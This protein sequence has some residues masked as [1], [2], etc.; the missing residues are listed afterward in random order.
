MSSAYPGDRSRLVK[1]TVPEQ[2]FAKLK[3][4]IRKAAPRTLDAISHAIAQALAT[5]LPN[6]CAN[7]LKGAGSD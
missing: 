3:G 2:V 5:I 1:L 4:F 6:E 7:Y